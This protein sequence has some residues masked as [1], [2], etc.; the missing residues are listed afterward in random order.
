MIDEA[1]VSSLLVSHWGLTAGQADEILRVVVDAG[2]V[3][4]GDPVG[5]VG[6]MDC[7]AKAAQS[8]E[9]S[10][11]LTAVQAPVARSATL[12]HRGD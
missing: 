1:A 9:P 7:P 4:G 10:L 11:D 3:V 8:V 2:H 12:H 5:E 6:R